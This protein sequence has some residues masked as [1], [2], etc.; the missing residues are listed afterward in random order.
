VTFADRDLI[1]ADHLG[2]WRAGTRQLRPHI[3]FIEF[4]NGI[5]IEVELPGY[6]LDRRL[7]AAPA[8]KVREPLG[9]ARVVGEKVEALAFHF[10][11]TPAKN[12]SHFQL[13]K[14]PGVAA[15]RITH[16]TDRAIIPTVVRA[17]DN[18]RTEFFE[19]QRSLMMRALG[20]RRSRTPSPPV[21]SL[22]MRMRPATAVFASLKP[23]SESPPHFDI[24][25]LQTLETLQ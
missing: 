9:E 3:L 14:Y 22:G 1:N 13:E 7:A 4:L 24:E 18:H 21:E 2:T 19:H 25:P 11:T 17:S 12:A 16:A 20:R 15:R 6:V 5:P 10:V 23:P 8:N